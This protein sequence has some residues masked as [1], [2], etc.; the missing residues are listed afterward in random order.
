VAQ[1]RNG[2]ARIAVLTI[3][4]EEFGAVS[5]A[6]SLAHHIPGS[7][8]YCSEAGAP[9]VVLRQAPDRSQVPAMNTAREMLEDYRPEALFLVGIA[10][11]IAGRSDVG[12][13]D[14]VVPNYVHYGEFRKLTS[15]GD[16]KRYIAFDQ[17][18]VS[19]HERCVHPARRGTWRE[20]ILV[21]PPE[22]CGPS[23]SI[24][25][26]LVSGEK[27]YGDPSHYEQRELVRH[28]SDAVAVDMESYG[29]GRAMFDARDTVNYNPR[30][31]IIRGIS[32]LVTAL[33][34]AEMPDPAA[35]QAESENN[36]Q[37]K[38]WKL[39]SAAVAA[40]LAAE[41]IGH[42]LASPDPRSTIGRS[43]ASVGRSQSRK[44][45]K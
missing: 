27:V 32:D 30:L 3:I 4:D 22:P 40:A 26:S 42:F 15:K 8:Y 2:T 11:G 16:L 12:L 39:Y 37:R 44:G 14:V 6:L 43:K 36:E 20:R 34:S 45:S 33:D 19:L 28:Y 29:V 24:V 17:P 10:G 1:G 5:K 7:A 41:V 23:N 18:T 13:G 9:E 35:S 25:G 31:L 38:K 21:E